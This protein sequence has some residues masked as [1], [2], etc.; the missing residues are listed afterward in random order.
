MRCE[1][2]NRSSMYDSLKPMDEDRKPTKSG[3]EA[4]LR[5]IR[6][7]YTYTSEVW[8][9]L[10]PCETTPWRTKTPVSRPSAEGSIYLDPPRTVSIFSL[11]DSLCRSRS[12]GQSDLKMNKLEQPKMYCV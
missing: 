2:E 5:E 12:G 9:R 11:H 1:P 6:D 4:L 3:G 7:R 10:G 8:T